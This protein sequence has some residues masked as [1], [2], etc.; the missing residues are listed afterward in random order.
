MDSNGSTELGATFREQNQG[1]I[2][3]HLQLLRWR[4]LEAF[5]QQD[6]RLAIY[7]VIIMCLSHSQ[8]LPTPFRTGMFI[9]IILLSLFHNCRLCVCEAA[10]LPFLFA[11]F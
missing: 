8:T 9:V 3:E 10:R 2:K 1:Q 11:G 5:F 4:D 6:F 7:S